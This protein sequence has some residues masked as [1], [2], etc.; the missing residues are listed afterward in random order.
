VFPAID[1]HRMSRT[2]VGVRPTL[3]AWAKN[4]DRLSREH[5]FYDHAP[6]G[7]P[8]FISVAGGKLAAYRQLSEEVATLIAKRVGNATPCVTHEK[9]LPGAEEPLDVDAMARDLPARSRLALGRM[10]YR[11]GVRSKRMLAACEVDPRQGAHCCGCEPVTEAEVRYAARNELATKLVDIR[12][13]T[14]LGMGACGGT[15]CLHRG[16]QLLAEEK[17]LSPPEMLVE[18]K[19]AMTGRFIG[20][21]PV[22]EGANLATEELNQAIHFLTG[23]MLPFWKAAAAVVRHTRTDPVPAPAD[24]P[25]TRIKHKEAATVIHPPPIGEGRA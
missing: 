1:K 15:R 24:G 23:N 19:D 20:K 16:A 8:G 11:H 25:P 13:R 17:D 6:Q 3:W 5:E 21:R 18:L 7:V 4:E 10:A 2:Y 9:P 22:L 14:R 12:R